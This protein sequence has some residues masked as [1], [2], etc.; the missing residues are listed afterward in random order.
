MASNPH[1]KRGQE[2]RTGTQ[3]TK[4]GDTQPDLWDS[5]MEEGLLHPWA[6]SCP[7]TPT[8]GGSAFSPKGG[9]AASMQEFSKDFDKDMMPI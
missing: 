8:G 5:D 7:G 1:P 3:N 6:S 4:P 9:K 2:R